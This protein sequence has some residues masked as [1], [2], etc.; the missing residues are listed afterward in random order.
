MAGLLQH[1]LHQALQ[2]HMLPLLGITDLA[3][4][5][6]TSTAAR[7]L[8]TGAPSALWQA[9]AQAALP[10]HPPLPSDRAL[11]Q[12][13]MCKQAT[14]GRK[15]ASGQHTLH[16]TVHSSK[17]SGG[18]GQPGW[19]SLS[20]DGQ[21]YVC[22]TAGPQRPNQA[23]VFHNLLS[24]EKTRMDFAEE[25]RIFS[26]HWHADGAHISLAQV[27]TRSERVHLSVVRWPAA[28]CVA[29]FEVSDSV[30]PEGEWCC[31]SPSGARGVMAS[32]PQLDN[33]PT[34]YCIADIY[35]QTT[36]RLA[37]PIEGATLWSPSNNMLAVL[38][39]NWTNP[40]Y[41][42]VI[43]DAT[44]GA[45]IC[46]IHTPS[47]LWVCDRWT[48]EGSLCWLEPDDT[49]LVV[50]GGADKMCVGLCSVRDGSMLVRSTDVVGKPFPTGCCM[51][52]DRQKIAIMYATH[53]VTE[54]EVLRL[55]TLSACS[56]TVSPERQ[57]H[58][59]FWSPCSRWLAS[60]CFDES[61]PPVLLYDTNS[62]DDT[63]QSQIC[64]PF[65]TASGRWAPDASF[66]SLASFSESVSGNPAGVDSVTTCMI[67]FE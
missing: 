56:S 67:S 39:K 38:D 5:A 61:C 7:E 49:L 46:H 21:T 24:G 32:T 17:G 41:D 30:D 58:I 9:A 53:Q 27:C 37:C 3:R 18:F 47:R 55:A 64:V 23:L 10:W 44:N 22:T 52:F 28:D 20:P 31:W 2:E 48:S 43:F 42:I 45:Q 16:T 6:C 54:M 40:A 12:A 8:V 57:G 4:L 14:C 36:V 26:G 11:V 50:L 34:A 13:A 60:V 15:L 35:A 1:H 25:R 63:P 66:L 19:S 59:A 65:K 29:S 62:Y 51:S 33:D